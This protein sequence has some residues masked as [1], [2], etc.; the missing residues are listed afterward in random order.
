MRAARPEARVGAGQD[1]DSSTRSHRRMH[2]SWTI[3]RE[4]LASV[5]GDVDR[6]R[7]ISERICEQMKKSPSRKQRLDLNA[8]LNEVIAWAQNIIV[9]NGVSVH[10]RFADGSLLV[11]G[12]RGQL[13]QVVMNLVLNA[14]EAMGLVE[15]GGR[16]LLVS[17]EQTASGVLVA[18]RDS[19]PGID[20]Q[21]R[22]RVFE[23]FYTTKINGAGMGLATADP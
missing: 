6:A 9:R 13:Q 3:A 1:V 16:E 18:V 10:A 4:A 15:T 2:A 11:Q 7:D 20:P 8:A 23:S 14:V 17:T 21:H 5:V 19:G 12:D 22:G